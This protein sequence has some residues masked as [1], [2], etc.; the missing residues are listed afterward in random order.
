MIKCSHQNKKHNKKSEERRA[1]EMK[2]TTTR[3]FFPHGIEGESMDCTYKDWNSLEKA[4]AYCHRYAKGI[5]FA[6]VE[7]R[8]DE[9]NMVYELLANGTVIDYRNK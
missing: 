5:R 7:I 3:F 8:D 2:Y 1:K 6:S 9:G 4:V